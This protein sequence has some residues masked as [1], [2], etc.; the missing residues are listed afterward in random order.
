MEAA[1]QLTGLIRLTMTS[2]TSEQEALDQPDFDCGAASAARPFSLAP[3]AHS[4]SQLYLNKERLRA[5][6]CLALGELSALMCEVWERA[7]RAG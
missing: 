2:R 6:T 4:L 7:R 5:V 1:Q 3:T